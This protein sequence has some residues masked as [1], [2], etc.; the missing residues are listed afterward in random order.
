L[1]ARNDFA[2]LSYD[3]VGWY[4]RSADQSW[5]FTYMLRAKCSLLRRAL[6]VAAVSTLVVAGAAPCRAQQDDSAPSAPVSNY[7]FHS[8]EED[9]AHIDTTHRYSSEAD[10]ANDALL[11]TEVKT[12]LADDGVIDGHAVVVDCDHGVVHLAGAVGSAA[13]AQHAIAVAS[14]VDG[15]VAVKN[16]LKW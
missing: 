2:D 9:H 13:D 16:D 6:F 15:V 4:M 12:A 7:Q 8:S 3:Q 1:I 5:E 14:R 11:I 10:R